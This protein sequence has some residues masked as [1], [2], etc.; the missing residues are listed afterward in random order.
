MVLIVYSVS[1]KQGCPIC[2]WKFNLNNCYLILSFKNKTLLQARW[3]L[4]AN[5][6]NCCNNAK[7]NGIIHVSKLAN[8]LNMLFFSSKCFQVFSNIVITTT[9]VKTANI[10]CHFPPTKFEIIFF[11]CLSQA[12]NGS[13]VRWNEHL[14][15]GKCLMTS[16]VASS[17]Q[18]TKLWQGSIQVPPMHVRFSGQSLF[19]EQP[20]SSPCRWQ[21]GGDPSN[22]WWKRYRK[23]MSSH[24]FVQF[25]LPLHL[26][27]Y[28]FFRKKVLV[29]SSQILWS[30]LPLTSFVD[31]PN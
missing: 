22:P 31:D 25:W 28:A 8:I 19:L 13:P 5:I 21:Y 30:S 26:Y 20:T 11:P 15:T 23:L 29:L 24:K 14:Q 7:N 18:T 16:H 27:R 17:P 1:Y 2:Y 10:C 6:F 12:R 3:Y 4:S 9:A